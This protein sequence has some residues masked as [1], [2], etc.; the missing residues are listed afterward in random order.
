MNSKTA[1]VLSLGLL[2][3]LFAGLARLTHQPDTIIIVTIPSWIRAAGA[4]GLL[5][6]VVFWLRAHLWAAAPNVER[7]ADWL[8]DDSAPRLVD[9]SIDES[10]V[11]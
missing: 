9:G 5:A 4:V 8:A 7:L 10:Q 11:R 2:A 1:I 6:I 3:I